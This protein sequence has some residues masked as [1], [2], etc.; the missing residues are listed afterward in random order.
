[1][2]NMSE[3]N[4]SYNWNAND[5]SNIITI[6]ASAL[7]SV[8]LVIFKSRCKTINLC[9][10]LINCIRDPKDESDGEEENNNNNNNNNNDNNN[11]NNDGENIIPNNNP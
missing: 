5:F 7:A 4:T 6:S 10:G 1:M 11:N 9:F 8:L 3:T 2:S